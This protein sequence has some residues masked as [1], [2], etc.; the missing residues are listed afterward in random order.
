MSTGLS[1]GQR[2][3][4]TS[5]L[6]L[7]ASKLLEDE[8]RIGIT[9][10]Y[11][12]EPSGAWALMPAS[13]SAGYSDTGWSHG[14]WFCGFWVGLLVAA[15]LHTRSDAYF[16]L[17]R[18]RMRLVTQRTDDPNTHDIGFI[19]ESSALRL[20]HAT[21]DLAQ[22]DIA[23]TAAQR[24][25]ARTIVTAR[26]AYLSSWGPLDDARARAAS[27]IDTMTN[28]PLLYWAAGHSGDE[29]FLL[30]AEAHAKTT[31]AGMVRDDWSTWHAVEYDTRSG[32]RRR[33]YTFQG[34][35]DESHWSR[36]QGWAIL[37]FAATAAATGNADY[38]DIAAHLFDA[39]RRCLGD[40]PIPPWDF[41]DPRGA[42]APR[43]SSAGAVVANGLLRMA[44]LT[45]D[46]AQ[47]ARWRGFALTTLEALCREALATDPRHRGLLRHGVYS[48]PQGIGTDSAV[49]FG[50]YFFTTALMRVL[51]PG[52]FVAADQ[53]LS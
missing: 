1:A 42:A 12:T 6:D 29:S 36:G 47:A 3:Q 44:D 17:A 16:G 35:A 43:D 4:F 38:I 31:R 53:K 49:L 22:A 26:G 10:P 9:F 8:A 46:A 41:D 34:Y 32:A 18:E 45:P 27:A 5:A 15:G 13:V 11:V 39:Y 21:G 51:Y 30:A 40:N 2:T 25:R 24:L 20:L 7:L 52:A 23:M 14:N 37:G 28:L 19:F 50:D 48:M 33:G